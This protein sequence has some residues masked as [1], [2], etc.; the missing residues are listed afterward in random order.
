MRFIVSVWD[1][2]I[3]RASGPNVNAGF[4]VRGRRERENMTFL[5]I[6]KARMRMPRVEV[7]V[8]GSEVQLV[9]KRI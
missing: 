2:M 9:R 6:E 4:A 5:R 8:P 3:K 7:I 1:R